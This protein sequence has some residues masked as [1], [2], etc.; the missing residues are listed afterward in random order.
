[1]GSRRRVVCIALSVSLLWFLLVLSLADRSNGRDATMT[2]VPSTASV[3]F[4]KP[5]ETGKSGVRDRNFNLNC[6]SKR[7]VPNGP[8][9]IH[10]RRVGSSRLPPT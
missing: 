8:D 7:R 6:V 1:M 5:I 9:P 10:N 4:L 2:T 3:K